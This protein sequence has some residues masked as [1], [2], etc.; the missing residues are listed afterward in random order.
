MN[1]FRLLSAFL[2]FFSA[3]LTAQTDFSQDTA[4]SLLKH[5][6]VDIGPRPMG[7]PAEQEALA[8]AVRKFREYG[9]DTAY[10]M[11]MSYTSTANTTS[12]I[13]VGIKPGTHSGLC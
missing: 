8:F 6:S 11:N 13:A 3:E 10:I 2:F 1:G 7:S 12:G 9:C 4:L 5:L